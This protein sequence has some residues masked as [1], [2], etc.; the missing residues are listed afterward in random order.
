M[1][2]GRMGVAAGQRTWNKP[3]AVNLR[4]VG[5]L[6]KPLM[7]LFV[8]HSAIYMLVEFNV[9]LYVPDLLDVLKVST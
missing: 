6:H 2:G 1:V 5:A 9:L 7:S 8:K 3:S 4:S